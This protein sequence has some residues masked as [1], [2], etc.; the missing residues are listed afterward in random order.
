MLLPN[1]R[2]LHRSNR[3]RGGDDASLFW[4]RVA[5]SNYTPLKRKVNHRSLSLDPLGPLSDE[6]PKVTRPLAWQC[7]GGLA[8]LDSNA[9]KRPQEYKRPAK[10]GDSQQAKHYYCHPRKLS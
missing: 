8:F 5:S 3:L 9:P 10:D 1:Y 6:T 2:F 4:L 7:T